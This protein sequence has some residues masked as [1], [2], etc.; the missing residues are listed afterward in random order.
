MKGY[1]IIPV[2]TT[3][4]NHKEA[5]SE[6]RALGLHNTEKLLDGEKFIIDGPAATVLNRTLTTH[7]YMLTETNIREISLG[8][9]LI[10]Q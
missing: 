5:C 3:G 10:E 8:P 9:R 7:G 6:L 2:A 4:T 1:Q